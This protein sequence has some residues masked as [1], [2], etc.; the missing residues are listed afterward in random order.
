[1][2][3]DGPAL[4]LRRLV[5]TLDRHRV[6]Y[7]VIGGI[8]AIAHGNKRATFDLDVTPDLDRRNLERLA[9]ALRE[10]EA[11][12]RGIGD[13]EHDLSPTNPDHL[14]LG[15]NWTLTTDAGSLDIMS[16]PTGAAPYAALDARSIDVQ[17]GEHTIKIVGR[18]DLIAMKRAAGRPKD[19]DDL[20]ALTIAVSDEPSAAPPPPQPPVQ[21]P[22]TTPRCDAPMPL[23]GRRC[24]LAPGHKGR[25][26]S[27]R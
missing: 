16:D 6:R 18:D 23:A 4:D 20:A 12:L 11:E 10:L 7:V 21:A 26:R 3:A 13:V 17:M 27:R 25:H 22:S 2:T 19:L 5:E 1:M 15:G 24:V 14:A 9:S 8:A